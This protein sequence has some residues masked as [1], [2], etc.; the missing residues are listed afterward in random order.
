ME[1]K[2]KS[3]TVTQ[4]D[5]I[6][7]NINDEELDIQGHPHHFSEFDETG[8]LMKEV[9]Y[10]RWGEFE[11]MVLYGY[12]PKGDLIRESYYS[13]E[14]EPAA[15]KTYERDDAGRVVRSFKKYLDG[16][17]DTTHYEY[18]DANR[19]TKKTT[20]T[21]EGEVEQTETF[22]WQ[23]ETIVE[24]EIL[25]GDGE[26]VLE[27]EGPRVNPGQ[28]RLTYNEKGQV[29][30]E[31][32]LNNEGEVYMTV[33]RTYL[34]NGEADEVHVFIDGQG[35]TISRHYFLKHAYTFFE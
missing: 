7:K 17:V 9:R 6:I 3:I 22:G 18:D 32:E 16:S 27:G 13:E 4:Y 12:D 11:E 1:K 25:D 34:E 10:N 2:I 28:S 20:V 14:N 21:D 31:E 5:Y 15:E 26:P 35:Q 19:L 29:T 30:R 24:H 23:D 8:N 33:D